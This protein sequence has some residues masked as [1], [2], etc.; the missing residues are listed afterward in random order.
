M[1]RKFYN[2]PDLWFMAINPKGDI[3]NGED[4]SAPMGPT[5]DEPG[6][7]EGNNDWT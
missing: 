1:R 3:L 2:K 6:I 7:G 5:P 4:V